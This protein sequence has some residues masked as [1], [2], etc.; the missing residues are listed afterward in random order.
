MS[1]LY[2]SGL[3]ETNGSYVP[4]TYAIQNVHVYKVAVK[5]VLN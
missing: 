5:K 3:S 4:Y 1:A 2:M